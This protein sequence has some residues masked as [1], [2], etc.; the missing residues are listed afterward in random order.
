[1]LLMLP[2]HYLLVGPRNGHVLLP[3]AACHICYI[4]AKYEREGNQIDK[5]VAVNDNLLKQPIKYKTQPSV[6]LQIKHNFLQQSL[7]AI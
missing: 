4:E 5:S 7:F 3:P 1:M 2:H 6:K